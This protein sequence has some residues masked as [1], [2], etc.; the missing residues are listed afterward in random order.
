MR[1]TQ[2]RT[3][4]GW[5]GIDLKQGSTTTLSSLSRVGRFDRRQGEA[6]CRH[7]RRLQRH[8][9]TAVGAHLTECSLDASG[10]RILEFGQSGHVSERRERVSERTAYSTGTP[11]AGLWCDNYA[12]PNILGSAFINTTVGEGLRFYRYSNASVDSCTVSSER[13]TRR[14]GQHVVS[15]VQ[16]LRVTD[17]TLNGILCRRLSRPAGLLVDHLRQQDRRLRRDGSVPESRRHDQ[18]RHWEQQHNEQHDRRRGQLHG[19]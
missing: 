13:R 19:R 1:S 4:G 6:V 15:Q 11:N 9:R 8:R 3:P 10:Q 12:T 7:Y 14:A 2:D 16:H 18:R 17:N 5:G